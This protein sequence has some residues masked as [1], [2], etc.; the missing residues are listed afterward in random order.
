MYKTFERLLAKS[1]KTIYQVA[2]ETGIPATTLYEW[3]RGSYQPKY[4]KIKKIADLFGV[5]VLLF[6]TEEGGEKHEP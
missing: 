1:G 2:K 6:F 5:S 3:K 4:D